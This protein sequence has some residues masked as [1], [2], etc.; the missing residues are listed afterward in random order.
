M[1]ALSP[2]TEMSADPANGHLDVDAAH[3]F[4]SLVRPVNLRKETGSEPRKLLKII[5]AND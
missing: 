2:Q 1:L 3:D 4:E 5:S